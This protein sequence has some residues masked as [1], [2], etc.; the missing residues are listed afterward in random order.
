MDDDKR[1]VILARR[2]DGQS[3][4]QIATAVKVSIGV[5]HK[6][7]NSAAAPADS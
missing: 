5:V 6:T 4:R 7:L 2:T 1:R 3:I